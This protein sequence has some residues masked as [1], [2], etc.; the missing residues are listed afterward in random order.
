[1]SRSELK[2]IIKEV[3]DSVRNEVLSEDYFARVKAT[4]LDKFVAQE[5][6]EAD[7]AANRAD[8]IGSWLLI[9]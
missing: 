3:V 1:M 7:I 4:P 9:H 6:S 8:V 2:Q 5:L